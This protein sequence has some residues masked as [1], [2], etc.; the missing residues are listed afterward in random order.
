ML[1]LPEDSH[2][3]L[4][5][6]TGTGCSSGLWGGFGLSWCFML[7]NVEAPEPAAPEVS[8]KQQNCSLGSVLGLQHT[9]DWAV[10]LYPLSSWSTCG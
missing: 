1:M 3:A 2:P 5:L 7:Q 4:A 10:P 9:V 8:C 6:A